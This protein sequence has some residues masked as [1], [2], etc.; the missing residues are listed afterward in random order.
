VRFS[1]IIPCFN[2]AQN[3][4][5]LL[6]SCLGVAKAGEVEVIIVDN[7]ST[8]DTPEV[9]A[10]ALKDFPGCRSIRL[11]L[12]QG[13]GFGILAGLNCSEGNVLGWTHA[14]LQTDPADV[15]VGLKYFEKYGD[16]VFSKGRRFGRPLLDTVFTFGMS[17]FES[18]FLLKP[19]WDI[20]A[21]PTL[22]TRDFFLTWDDPP[23]DFS[24][25]LYA[26][27]MAK[28]H[29]LSVHRFPVYFGSRA[30]GTSHWNVNWKAKLIFIQKTLSYSVRLKR[31]LHK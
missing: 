9:L 25:D 7:G 16:G 11:E 10:Q 14:D 1:L 31:K 28:K 30:F 21:Q 5:L 3:I 24:L 12:N 2:E 17:L 29:G 8:D 4:P 6:A 23:H 26:Y 20:N 13:Y 27:F 15:L 22:F 18:V 19:M